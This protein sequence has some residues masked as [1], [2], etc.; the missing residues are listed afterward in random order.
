MN[1]KDVRGNGAGSLGIEPEKSYKIRQ[2]ALA[3]YCPGAAEGRLSH[4]ALHRGGEGGGG[5]TQQ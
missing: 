1:G 2:N 5:T 4:S 3:P